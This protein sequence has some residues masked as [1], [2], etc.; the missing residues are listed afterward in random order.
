MV[1]YSLQLHGLLLFMFDSAK[2]KCIVCPCSWNAQTTSAPITASSQFYLYIPM[3]NFGGSNN[4]TEHI[5]IW[6]LHG[7]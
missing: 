4:I 2:K 7:C 1:V 6:Q 5:K 3:Q